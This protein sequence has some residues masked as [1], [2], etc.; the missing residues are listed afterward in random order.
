MRGMRAPNAQPRDDPA[1]EIMAMMIPLR[2]RVLD[3]SSVAS[4]AP[5]PATGYSLF[6]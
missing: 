1:S 5:A 2:L 4:A 6:K 3:S